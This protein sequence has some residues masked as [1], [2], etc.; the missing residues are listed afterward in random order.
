VS[1]V[2][3]AQKSRGIALGGDLCGA[4]VTLQPHRAHVHLPHLF[5]LLRSKWRPAVRIRRPTWHRQLHYRHV[6]SLRKHLRQVSTEI[7]AW[8]GAQV[9]DAFVI[10]L[11]VSGEG[12]IMALL[13]ELWQCVRRDSPGELGG[14]RG[15]GG[16]LDIEPVAVTSLPVDVVLCHAA[17]L[18]FPAHVRVKPLKL[19]IVLRSARASPTFLCQR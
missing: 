5:G 9:P 18:L 10:G 14:T 15:E 13:A 1:R 3:P 7:V 11:S 19:H 16:W 2:I 12:K 17:P 8:V 6:P 4:N